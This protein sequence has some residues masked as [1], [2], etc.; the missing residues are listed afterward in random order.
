[1]GTERAPVIQVELYSLTSDYTGSLEA[2]KPI[3]IFNL[4]QVVIMFLE[5]E[6]IMFVMVV[7]YKYKIQIPKIVFVVP[8]LGL[9]IIYNTTTAIELPAI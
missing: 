4:L 8:L 5:T 2:V 1:M 9:V 3:Y 7:K 6:V